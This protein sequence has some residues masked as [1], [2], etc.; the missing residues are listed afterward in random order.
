MVAEKVLQHRRIKATEERRRVL[1][2]R[3]HMGDSKAP[4]SVSMSTVVDTAIEPEG[5]RVSTLMPT[6]GGD[7]VDGMSMSMCGAMAVAMAIHVA[8]AARKYCAATS[9][10][11]RADTLTAA[12]Q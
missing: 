11:W 2:I 8:V 1:V 3:E 6:A 9:S 12:L 4:M 7:M 10:A 5:A